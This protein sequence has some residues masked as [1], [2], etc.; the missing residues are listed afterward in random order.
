MTKPIVYF[1]M[2]GT[3]VDFQSGIDAV[4]AQGRELNRGD[5]DWDDVEG[6]FSLMKPM[7]GA[8]EAAKLIAQDFDVY[9][10]SKSPWNN[11]SAP[12]DKLSWIKRY[13]GSDEGSIFYKRVILSGHKHLSRGDFLIDDRC[14]EVEDHFEGIH[15]KFNS[16]EFPDWASV[17]AALSAYTNDGTA[18][19]ACRGC[20]PSRH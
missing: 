2:D 13:F 17:L 8:I 15:I 14:P 20:Q 7:P 5:K 1:D 19:P 12:S 9:V 11:V 4:L 3:V 18:I 10:L 6:I 16:P